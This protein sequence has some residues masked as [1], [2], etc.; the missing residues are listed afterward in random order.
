MPKQDNNR[1]ISPRDLHV[2]CCHENSLLA[3]L[4]LRQSE[5]SSMFCIALDV[6]KE[7]TYGVVL[8][9]ASGH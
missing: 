7:S 6:H 5:V 1:F 8:D 2:Q 3:P 9:D 4:A